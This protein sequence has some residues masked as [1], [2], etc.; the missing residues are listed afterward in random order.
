MKMKVIC[1]KANKFDFCKTCL[2]SEPH[3]TEELSQN[4]KCTNWGSCDK[5][6]YGDFIKVRCVQ[7]KNKEEV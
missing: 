2:H 1:N 7:F 4:T 3:F 6:G 5:T